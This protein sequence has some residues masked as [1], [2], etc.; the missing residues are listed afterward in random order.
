MYKKKY[1]IAA[2]H[3]SFIIYSAFMYMYLY[4]ILVLILISHIIVSFNYLTDYWMVKFSWGPQVGC[5]GLGGTPGK[6]GKRG[7]RCKSLRLEQ[8]PRPAAPV[9]LHKS[10]HHAAAG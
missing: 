1:M 5:Q 9:T 6:P 4:I 8:L 7:Q 2:F 3:I 10:L